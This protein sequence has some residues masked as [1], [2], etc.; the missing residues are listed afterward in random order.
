MWLAIVGV[1]LPL[2]SIIAWRRAAAAGA[3]T[4]ADA[5]VFQGAR[6]LSVTTLFAWVVAVSA[7]LLRA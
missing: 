7:W 1:V 2:L 6:W 5:P 4:E 3:P